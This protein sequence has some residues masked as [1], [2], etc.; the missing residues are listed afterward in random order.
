[1]KSDTQFYCAIGAWVAVIGLYGHFV[2]SPF[3]LT[4]AAYTSAL[5]LFALSINVMLGGVGEVPLGHCLF[6]GV[7]AYGVGI[8]MKH[9]GMSYGTGVLIGIVA[10]MTLACVV[11]ALTL[12]LSGA[13]FAIVSWGLAGV[14]V[15]VAL[16][17]EPITGGSMGLFGL[18]SMT[19]LSLDL[20]R[21]DRY[22][23]VSAAVLVVAV[24]LLNA[25]R[26][27]SFGVALESIRQNRHLAAS[28]GIAV[29]RQRLK[30]FVCS[31]A[32][33]SVAGA[34][35][36]PY[37]QIVTPESLGVNLTV[38]ALLMVL[39][40]G[41]RWI[42]GPIVGAVVFSILPFY[43]EMDANVRLLAFSIAIILIMIFVPGGFHQLG[44]AAVS[45]LKEKCFERS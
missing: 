27:A 10:S 32:L 38:D 39:L 15:V 9:L 12:R 16:N 28:V 25:L 20:S 33:A 34:L 44:L 36:V 18:P 5:A 31:A 1:M 30:A 43:L 4:L 2:Q 21:A 19:I 42:F 29:F 24:I 22:F 45:R 8:S 17:L 26:H 14:A 40:G 41:A 37:T 11:G 6:Y 7:G 35:T 23:Y 13:Y 3:L